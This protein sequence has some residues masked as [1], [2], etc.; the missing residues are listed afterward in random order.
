M[1]QIIL[2]FLYL[3]KKNKINSTRR[4]LLLEFVGLFDFFCAFI[5]FF[6]SVLKIA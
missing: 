2:L 6:S 1:H 4:S 3:L 5:N